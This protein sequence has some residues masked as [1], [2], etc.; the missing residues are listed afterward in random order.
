[1][2]LCLIFLIDGIY[3]T[4]FLVGLSKRVAGY[5]SVFF[6]QKRQQYQSQGNTRQNQGNKAQARQQGNKF[7]E[8]IW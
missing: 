6:R 5:F 8:G 4:C 7:Q 1:M 2:S 3:W